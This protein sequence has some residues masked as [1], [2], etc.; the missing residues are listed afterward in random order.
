MLCCKHQSNTQRLN[1]MN[2]L[3]C[4]GVKTGSLVRRWVA[5]LT[6]CNHTCVQRH[7]SAATTPRQHKKEHLKSPL[8]ERR[9]EPLI[10]VSKIVLECEQVRLCRDTTLPF[11]M[12]VQRLFQANHALVL[13]DAVHCLL[14]PNLANTQKPSAPLS[15]VMASVSRFSSTIFKQS[16][17]KPSRTQRAKNNTRTCSLWCTCESREN[18]FM[19]DKFPVFECS[20]WP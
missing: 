7:Y 20:A 9:I 19:R 5:F 8:E 4:S 10:E 3:Q 13:E 12:A 2:H 1:K 11:R 6:W 16:M 18:N 15:T 14:Q 17:V